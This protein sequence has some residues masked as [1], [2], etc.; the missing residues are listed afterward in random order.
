MKFKFK[1]AKYSFFKSSR[2]KPFCKPCEKKF[3]GQNF[4]FLKCFLWKYLRPI[5]K[6]LTHCL[7]LNVSYRPCL[8]IIYY[9]FWMLKTFNVCFLGKKTTYFL[10]HHSLKKF[11]C[12]S[13]LAYPKAAYDLVT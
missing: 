5:K 11:L 1:T 7:D 2:L 4:L 10:R 6:S 8:L 3:V 12:D 13:M 9:Q